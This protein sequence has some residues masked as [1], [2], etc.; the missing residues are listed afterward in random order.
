MLLYYY[1][2]TLKFVDKKILLQLCFNAILQASSTHLFQ[3]KNKD[4]PKAASFLR[5]IWKEILDKWS[6]VNKNMKEKDLLQ[7]Y[8]HLIEAMFHTK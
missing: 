3:L 5:N 7:P 4:T 2:S 1:L 6:S 8:C